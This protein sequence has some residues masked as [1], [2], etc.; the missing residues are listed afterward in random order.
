MIITRNYAKRLVRQGKATEDGATNHNGQRY[1]IVT[2]HYLQRVDHYV[3]DPGQLA[4]V[5]VQRSERHTD[6][7]N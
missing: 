6:P 1:Q 2:R 3:L 5:Q 4:V 7:I